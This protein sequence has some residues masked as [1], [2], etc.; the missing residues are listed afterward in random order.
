[1]SEFIDKTECQCVRLFPRGGGI[2]AA[3]SGGVDS[4]V[5]LDILHRLAE[6]HRW[7]IVIAH[8]N[9]QLR[10]RSSDGDQRLVEGVAA[11]LKLPIVAQR[12]D[13]RAIASTSRGSIEMAARRVRHEF[14]ARVARENDI[15]TVAL[16]HHADD[17]VELFFLRLFRGAGADGLA[18]MQ[19]LSASP[20]DQHVKL[21]RPLLGIP[22][23]E[24]EEYARGEHI[25]FREDAT[26]DSL[27]HMRNRI[28]HELLPGLESKYQP[29][30]REVI[31]RTMDVLAAEAECGAKLA[32][33]WLKKR[34][35]DFEKL[36]LAVQRRVLQLQL[37]EEGIPPDFEL[38][39]R[40]RREPDKACSFGV[41]Q[42]LQRSRA[43]QLIRRQ[44]AREFN[45]DRLGVDLNAERQAQFGG[46]QISWRRT[47][48][49][50]APP[51]N[52]RPQAERFDADAIGERIVLRHWRPGDRFQPSGMKNTAKLQDL[53]A[54]A[55]V[56]RTQ[57]HG[58]IVAAT[59]AGE[60]FWVEGLRISERFKLRPQT[61]RVLE[62]KW[63]RS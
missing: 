40:L 29:A 27:D 19:A 37:I 48:V 18:G 61:R 53:F 59:A 7:R 58:Y 51:I 45:E 12:A 14:L 22:R 10:G 42:H 62:W 55:K 16:A 41:D 24:I 4:M 23:S 5:L 3:V 8:L 25:A 17:Q 9:H 15:A 31:L 33:D 44:S 56:P 52:R 20:A 13:I 63:R 39:E 47:V 57:R 28:R 38:I 21:A 49:K 6:K 26:N 11:K 34:Q 54:N 60:I 46:L 36:P 2:L 32:A 1:V 35:V 43:G 50:E 30:I